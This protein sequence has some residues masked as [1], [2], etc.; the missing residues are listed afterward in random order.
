MGDRLYA[1]YHLAVYRGLRRGE[2]VALRWA[3]VDLDDG[4]VEVRRNIVQLGK[5]TE[6]GAPDEGTT[7][8]DGLTGA[9][10]WAIT[11]VALAAVCLFG[12]GAAG[13]YTSVTHLAATH[14]VPLPRL[15][16]VDIDGG[17]VGTVLLDIVLTWTGY[18]VCG[19]AG[20]PAGSPSA[21]SQRTPR[22]AGRT[23]SPPVFTWPR[24]S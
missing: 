7:S 14:L 4:F 9:Q 3:D 19:C 13:S 8:G 10:R 11:G 12:Y 5:Q 1:L 23:Q 24:R 6:E 15:V 22:S 17:L 2:L 16:P 20:W 18:L 21:R